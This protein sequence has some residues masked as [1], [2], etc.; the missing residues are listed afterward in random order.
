MVLDG[1]VRPPRQQPGNGGPPVTVARVRRHDGLVLGGG[2]G[3]VLDARA[4]LVA[5]PE[6]ARLPGPPLDVAAN[7]GPVPR[8]V[9]LHQTGEDLV[10][11]GAPWALDPVRLGP[12]VISSRRRRLIGRG[13]VRG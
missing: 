5:P 2:E 8:A 11:L 10:L 6:P 13:R 4:Q 7:E 1:V 12:T 9:A 3:A